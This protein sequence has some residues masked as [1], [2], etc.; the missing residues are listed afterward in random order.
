MPRPRFNKLPEDKKERILEI[1]AR[2]FAYH[3]FDDASLNHILSEA[4]I[5]KGA[6]YYYFDDKTDLFATVIEHFLVGLFEQ[7]K[8]VFLTA[9]KQSFWDVLHS[10]CLDL[11]NECS[12]KPWTLGL[13]KA[14]GRF[15]FPR[16]P[17]EW[18]PL[19]HLIE[20][21]DRWFLTFIQRGQEVGVVRTDLPV[22]LL[23][24]WLW[25]LD[26][27]IDRW[28]ADHFQSISYDEA[29]GIADLTVDTFR[30]LLEPP[31]V[32][33]RWFIIPKTNTQGEKNVSNKSEK[34]GVHPSPKK[35]ASR[36]MARR[37]NDQ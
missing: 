18:G 25:S 21:G 24:A 19:S 20:A 22:D 32:H 13:I 28:I 35:K 30:R 9:T 8:D 2:E 5:S 4:G 12:K 16:D 14:V 15:S 33:K 11:I 6:A 27:A 17:A 7:T 34:K 3:G 10:V 1:S 37:K 36:S 31:Q 26:E 23:L 29:Q